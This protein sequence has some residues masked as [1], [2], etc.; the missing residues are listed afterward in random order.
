MEHGFLSLVPGINKQTTVKGHF[1]FHDYLNGF[2]SVLPTR[3]EGCSW[4]SVRGSGS[5]ASLRTPGAGCKMQLSGRKLLVIGL[6]R[7]REFYQAVLPEPGSGAHCWT[8][9]VRASKVQEHRVSWKW[10]R[11]I[12][13]KLRRRQGSKSRSTVWGWALLIFSQR[14]KIKS[15]KV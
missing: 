8:H 1:F 6:E 4:I 15:Y 5:M 13:H 11:A 14:K 3:R 7:F 2:P 12:F 10:K 9:P